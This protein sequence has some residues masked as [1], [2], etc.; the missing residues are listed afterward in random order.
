ME[1]TLEI[2]KARKVDYKRTHRDIIQGLL[3]SADPL[4]IKPEDGDV[5]VLTLDMD[6]ASCTFTSCLQKINNRTKISTASIAVRNEAHVAIEQTVSS[7][8]V[9]CND[10]LTVLG[11]FIHQVGP[12]LDQMAGPSRSRRLTDSLDSLKSKAQTRNDTIT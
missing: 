10:N 4:G 5:P 8:F 3:R 12:H 1:E 9:F 2:L 11:L 7:S 6:W